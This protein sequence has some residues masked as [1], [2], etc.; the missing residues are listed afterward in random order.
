MILLS[1]GSPLR[2]DSPLMY[3]SPLSCDSPYSW[4]S[5]LRCDSPLYFPS[6]TEIENSKQ[7]LTKLIDRFDTFEI[8]DKKFKDIKQSLVVLNRRLSRTLCERKDSMLG[9]KEY[10]FEFSSLKTFEFKDIDIENFFG[11]F[12][13]VEIVNEQ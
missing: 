13:E 8:N 4:Y 9:D 2:C 7:E 3:G 12:K 6:C 1:Y 11:C 10:A 5:P